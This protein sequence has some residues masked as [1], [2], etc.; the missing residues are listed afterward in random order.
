VRILFV[1][2][3]N[4]GIDPISTR[5]G[6]SLRREGVEVAYFDIIGKGIPGYLSNIFRL[7]K[8]VRNS[9]T[10]LIHT[11][12]SFGGFLSSMSFT[13]KPVIASLMGSDV[14]KSSWF[15]LL[16]IR[17]FSRYFWSCTIVK[18]S[19]MYSTL[20]SKR[21]EIIPNGVDM[22][23]F[24]QGDP[25]DSLKYLNW[26][27]N[28]KHILFASDPARPEKNFQLAEDAVNI[29]R[30]KIPLKIEVHSL[31]KISPEIVFRYYQASDVLLLTSFHEGSPNVIKEAMSCNCPIVSTDVGD[32]K[33][34]ISDTENCFITT[35]DPVEVADK[36]QLVLASG[37]RTNGH[38]KVQHLDDKIIASKLIAIYKSKLSHNIK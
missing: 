31:T 22:K 34:I 17:F 12:Y 18:S 3:G 37:K 19:L 8:T 20:G 1:R 32:I 13:G 25:H 23:T 24:S 2:G 7:R 27:S 21:V 33:E 26:D 11:H 28:S 15:L 35:F 14:L 6:E 9:K 29:I 5:Q 16:G 4:R 36:L 10:E 38:V 30:K